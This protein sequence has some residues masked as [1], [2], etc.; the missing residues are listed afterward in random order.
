MG[1]S[2]SSAVACRTHSVEE[3]EEG[4]WGGVQGSGG[5]WTSYRGGA[6]LAGQ[7]SHNAGEAHHLAM[8]GRACEVAFTLD[9]P[10]CVTH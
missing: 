5:V 6:Y 3:G 9:Q 1:S 8:P 10:I 2:W 4:R 7:D